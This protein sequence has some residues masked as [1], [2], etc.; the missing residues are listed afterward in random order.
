MFDHP[1]C[2]RLTLVAMLS[3]IPLPKQLNGQAAASYSDASNLTPDQIIYWYSAD[4]WEEFIKEWVIGL[5]KDYVKVQRLGGTSDRGI[6]IAALC[7]PSGLEGVW[8]CYQCKNYGRVV[9]QSIL[10]PELI[11]IFSG[12]V[13]GSYTLPRKYVIVAPKGC[14]SSLRK[15]LLLPTELRDDFLTHMDKQKSEKPQFLGSLFADIRL[16]ATTTDFSRFEEAQLDKIIEI[17]KKTPHHVRRFRTTLA[18][19]PKTPEPPPDVQ[20]EETVYIQQLME[21][22]AEESGGKVATRDDV[23]KESW[24]CNHLARQRRS[25]YSA[26]ALR[27]FA[28][29]QVP[30]GAFTKLQDDICHG[31]VEIEQASYPNGM[32]RLNDVLKTAIAIDLGSHM[33]YPRIDQQDRHG[34]CHQLANDERLRWCGEKKDDAGQ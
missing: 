19:R 18:E 20:N 10:F 33:L 3:D 28:R 26:E 22:Y 21:V 13:A 16:V 31:V 30:N 15:Q 2:E 32:E 25:F 34:I 27:V 14:G 24:Y 5:E 4:E 9:T 11:K 6:D 17:H 7:T 8:D 29:D 1:K 12:V 23:A